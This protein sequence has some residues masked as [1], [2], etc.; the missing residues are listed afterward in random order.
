MTMTVGKRVGLTVSIILGVTIVLAIV[1]I[2]E[3]V[4]V[5][6]TIDD[7]D[8]NKK[9]GFFAKLF[10]G[11][12]EEAE[13]EE[14]KPARPVARKPVQRPLNPKATKTNRPKPAA[15]VVDRPAPEAR[16]PSRP[17]S[18]PTPVTTLVGATPPPKMLPEAVTRVVSTTISNSVT[19]MP[20]LGKV[21]PRWVSV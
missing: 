7:L 14:A 20:G 19:G 13:P 2:N 11:G 10:G 21:P 3:T 5:K 16:P 4:G 8:P 9:Q 17:D 18:T 15:R 6:K 1:G 12:E